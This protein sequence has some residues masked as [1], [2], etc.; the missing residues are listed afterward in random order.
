[1]TGVMPESFRFP[2]PETE[3]RLPYPL[4][5]PRSR[6]SLIARVDHEAS[7]ETASEQVAGTPARAVNQL[8]VGDAHDKVAPERKR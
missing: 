7:V 8:N 5:P 6:V 3:F 4:A 2:D 1:M